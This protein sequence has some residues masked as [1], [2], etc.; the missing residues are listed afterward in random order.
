MAQNQTGHP[1]RERYLTAGELSAALA[2]LGIRP[3]SY[4]ACLEII[5]YCEATVGTTLRLSDAIEYLRIHRVHP[6]S[7]DEHKRR[8]TL[9]N[10]KSASIVLL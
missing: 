7:K 1:A 3:S 5:R 4:H 8:P 10:A 9:K 6:R 2:D